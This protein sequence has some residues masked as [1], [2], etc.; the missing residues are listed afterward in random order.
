MINDKVSFSEN[1]IVI[2]VAFLNEIVAQVKDALAERVGRM[3][4]D[5]DWPVWLECL[6]LDAGLRE[7][8]NEIQ[9]LLL[10]DDSVRTMTCCR[11]ADIDALDGMACRTSVGEFSFSCVTPADITSCEELF[12]DLMQLALDAANVQRLLLIPHQP[13]YGTRVEEALCK[14]SEEKAC[15]KV[16]YF[17]MDSPVG[18]QPFRSDLVNYSLLHAFGIRSEELF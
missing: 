4:P 16:L 15:E 17:R 13:A 18:P 10:H 12:L 1:V 2:D 5:I 3:L 6:A 7:G 11:P 14:I 9:V 8:G